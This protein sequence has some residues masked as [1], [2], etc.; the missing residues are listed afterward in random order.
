MLA[1]GE[2]AKTG[3]LDN[4]IF[5]IPSDMSVGTCAVAVLPVRIVAPF[6]V[7]YDISSNA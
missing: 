5:A 6:S 1:A 2:G 4:V 7:P 3:H